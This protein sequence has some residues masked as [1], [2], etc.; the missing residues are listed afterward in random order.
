MV[1]VAVLALL[2][3][4]PDDKPVGSVSIAINEEDLILTT[5]F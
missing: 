3:K 5:C 2:A 4:T 1:T